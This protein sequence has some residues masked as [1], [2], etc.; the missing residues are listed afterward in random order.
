MITL[1]E[2]TAVER[3]NVLL[4]QMIELEDKINPGF[5]SPIIVGIGY[6]QNCPYRGRIRSRREQGNCVTCRR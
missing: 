2:V 3:I 1:Y 5:I 4:E 6:S